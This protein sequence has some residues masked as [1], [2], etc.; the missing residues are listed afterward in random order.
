MY[1]TGN[2][3][4]RLAVKLFLL[5]RDHRSVAHQPV[6]FGQAGGAVHAL[7][8]DLQSCRPIQKQRQAALEAVAVQ[9]YQHVQT[10]IHNVLCQGRVRNVTKLPDAILRVIDI[11][12]L[13]RRRRSIGEEVD[14]EAVAIM[15][16]EDAHIHLHPVARAE[17]RSEIA[18]PQFASRFVWRCGDAVHTAR[19]PLD[20]APPCR[21]NGGIVLLR[22]ARRNA[23]DAAQRDRP[24]LGI[25]ALRCALILG[26]RSVGFAE[27]E[28]C[29]GQVAADHI[30]VRHQAH[31]MTQRIGRIRVHLQ[32]QAGA[33]E[34]VPGRM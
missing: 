26:D 19:L 14:L 6:D 33:A 25:G 22:S 24:H 21:Q 11:A 34:A 30:R 18:D 13:R 29:F 28:Q 9:V 16:V 15:G 3:N 10:R 7:P 1:R 17:E 2:P 4:D 12:G 20:P 23:G 27:V 8:A 32:R 5:W 31:G